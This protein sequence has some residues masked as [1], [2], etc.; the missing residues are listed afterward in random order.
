M[1]SKKLCTAL[2][3]DGKV[4]L[5]LMGFGPGPAALGKIH[6]KEIVE[7][8]SNS[9]NNMV[10]IVLGSNGRITG[11][12]LKTIET[13]A[14]LLLSKLRDSGVIVFFPGD[15]SE[16][17]STEQILQE[18][19]RREICK[20][21]ISGQGTVALKIRK[22]AVGRFCTVNHEQMTELVQDRVNFAISGFKRTMLTEAALLQIESAVEAELLKL[23]EQG[24]IE[25]VESDEFG[26]ETTNQEQVE[27]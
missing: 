11:D 22:M 17:V 25:F 19:K 3:R 23:E 20:A 14:E 26:D 10:R 1:E 5:D 12:K 15:D 16:L 18:E 7:G 4:H 13:R 8:I 6:G 27:Q 9:L 21:E 24:M 2:N